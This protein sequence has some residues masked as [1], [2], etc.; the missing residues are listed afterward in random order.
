M[1]KATIVSLY[2]LEF[3]EFIPFVFPSRYVVP[4]S[5]GKV[6]QVL[7]ISDSYYIV[8]NWV[9]DNNI[10]LKIP[11]PAEEQADSVVRDFLT[12]CPQ[13][14][15]DSAPAIFWLPGEVSKE[16]VIKN[17]SSKIAKALLRQKSWLT[18]LVQQAD[19]DW[20][21]FRSHRS[22]TDLQRLAVKLLGLDR[23][24]MIVTKDLAMCPACGTSVV[25]TQA[26]CGNCRCIINKAAYDKLQFAGA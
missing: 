23:E 19:D 14:D 21:R 22:I 10:P 24:Y 8:D 17:H 20:Q 12:S 26:L 2:P 11:I 4:E 13:V 9:G 7:T 25:P 1:S 15:E 3:N 6:P 5:D 16:D 18:R